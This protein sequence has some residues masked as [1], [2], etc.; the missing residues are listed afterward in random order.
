MSNLLSLHPAV[1]DARSRLR[2]DRDKARL[3]HDSGASGQQVCFFWTN[4]V[5][6][7]LNDVIAAAAQ[8]AG[9][10]SSLPGISLVAHGGYGRRDLAPYSDI[11]LML[12]YRRSQEPAV[13]PFA[14]AVAQMIV[15]SGLQ[16]G[17][18]TRTSRQARSLAWNDPVVF[19]SLVESRLLAG[20]ENL[21]RRFRSAFRTG[22]HSRSRWLIPAIQESRREEQEQFGEITYLLHPNIKRSRGGLRDLQMVRWIGF[23][24]YGEAEPEQLHQ[25]HL[26]TLEDYQSLREGRSFLLRLRN[27]MHFLAERED[28]MLDRAK[29]IRLAGWAGFQDSDGMLAVEQFMQQFFSFTSDIRYSATHFVESTRNSFAYATKV[30]RIFSRPLGADYRIGV[31]EIWPTRPQLNAM[32][33]DPSKV[34]ELMLLANNHNRRIDHHTWLTIREAMLRKP[35]APPSNETIARFSLLMQQ[36]R[37]LGPTLRRLH[38][39]RV[40][41]QIIPGFKHARYLLQFNEYHK[42][43]VDAHCIRSVQAATEF[44][45]SDGILGVAYRNIKNKALLHLTLLIHD[46]GKGFVE[47]HSEVGARIAD[48]TAT[49]L[50]LQPDEQEMLVFLVLKHLIMAHTAFRFDLAEKNTIVAFASAVGSVEVLRM[51]FLVTCAD[52]E[53]VG[54]GT[55]NDWKLNLIKQL[56]QSTLAEFGEGESGR[57]GS[58]VSEVEIRRR[59]VAN[60]IAKRS[61]TDWWESQVAKIP[62]AYLLLLPPEEIVDEMSRLQKLTPEKSI[63]VWG[64]FHAQ[65]NATQYVVAVRQEIPIGLFA[66][67]TGALTS[68]G[69]HILSGEVHTQPTEIAWDR[70]LVEDRDYGGEPPKHRIEEVCA[71]ILASLEAD[72]IATPTYRSVWTNRLESKTLIRNQPTQ[73]RFD[74][75]TSDKYTIITIFA[76]DRTGLLFDISRTL[77]KLDLVLHSA[78]FSTHLDQVVDVFYVTTIELKKIQEATRLYTLRQ[79]LIAAI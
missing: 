52:L 61:P 53:A 77:A 7:I 40:L 5:D 23:A 9:I 22:A 12:L 57:D 51:L 50:R 19:T 60:L 24:R 26:L 10:D 66:R 68:L 62:M 73:V 58:F 17:F 1:V 44:A 46:L 56:Y 74:N 18:S 79:R 34:I 67:I 38:E 36:P 41:E 33:E 65:Q 31:R 4:A 35:P 69:L 72:K 45:E 39:L 25:M 42:Y 32:K 75:S 78:K 64:N 71:K 16:L 30:S 55:L 11:D 49:L 63:A 13:I 76:Y 8:T 47:D 43:T 27:Q 3:Q 20:D 70:F 21:F 28:D 2:E 6:N 29:Q 54:P 48:E 14:R 37:K 15:D 59:T